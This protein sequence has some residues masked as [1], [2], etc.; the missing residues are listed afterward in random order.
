MPTLSNPQG[1][2]F[3]EL[4]IAPS[5][6]DTVTG[7][8][9]QQQMG[10]ARTA[11]NEQVI[12]GNGVIRGAD[13]DVLHCSF[14]SAGAAFDVA[15]GILEWFREASMD[16][17]QDIDGSACIALAYGPVEVS[18]ACQISGEGLTSAGVLLTSAGPGEVVV[19]AS[20]ADALAGHERA[21][22]LV[23]I[24]NPPEAGARHLVVDA[25]QRGE[26]ATRHMDPPVSVPSGS[27]DAPPEAQTVDA[28]DSA[29][30]D[31]SEL[32][33]AAGEASVDAGSGGVPDGADS[34]RSETAGPRISLVIGDKTYRFGADTNPVW[35]GRSSDCHV[36]I[37]HPHVSRRH[38]QLQWNGSEVTL[39]NLSANGSSV[40]FD[41]EAEGDIHQAPVSLSRG[42]EIAL[43]G[44]FQADSE[45][46]IRFTI[47]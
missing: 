4:D 18:D 23:E 34:S 9:A 30:L 8:L 37:P 32:E 44:T 45:R 40:R 22:E 43:A 25:R 2:L 24:D 36:V 3:I 47:E 12:A 19:S 17:E 28:E 27:A 5:M 31:I 41:D 38:A 11:I 15:V 14:A 20:A 6:E 33:D 46:V 1:S 29:D 26:S 35:I 10:H 42:G 7:W 16:P 39:V 13:G 21:S